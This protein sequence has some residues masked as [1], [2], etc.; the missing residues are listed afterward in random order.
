MK[1]RGFLTTAGAAG[2]N[3]K[4]TFDYH[5]ILDDKDINTLR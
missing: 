4:G 5:Q 1:R 3:V 2:E